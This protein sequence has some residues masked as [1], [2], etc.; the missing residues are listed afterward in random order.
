MI[1]LWKAFAPTTANG[2]VFETFAV[3]S[4]CQM[5]EKKNILAYI[6]QLMTDR[7]NLVSRPFD[8]EDEV[9]V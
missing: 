9:D 6:D 7:C 8:G 1:M 2:G 3:Q 5:M 4:H